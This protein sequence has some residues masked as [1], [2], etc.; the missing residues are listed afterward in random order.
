M[1]T[2]DMPFQMFGYKCFMLKQGNIEKFESQ[3]PNKLFIG[4]ALHSRPYHILNLDTNHVV[5]TCEVIFDETIICIILFLEHA[6]HGDMGQ[7]IF[8]KEKQ[9]DTDWG[10]LEPP[11][12]A[13]LIEHASTTLADGPNVTS[14]TN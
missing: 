14:S 11:R 7:T 5:E 10:D 12:L 3:Y 13:A 2:Q 9:C 1:T 4:Y 8:V 6:N